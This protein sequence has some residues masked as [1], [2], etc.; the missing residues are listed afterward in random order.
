ML[1]CMSKRPRILVETSEVMRR[2]VNAIAAASGISPS[3]LVNAALK[4]F[5]P[6][7]EFERI[8]KIMDADLASGAEPQGSRRGRKPKATE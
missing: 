8:K 6:A 1:S 7:A 3:D 4:A 2:T 5:I